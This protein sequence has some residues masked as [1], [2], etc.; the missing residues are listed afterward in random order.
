[1]IFELHFYSDTYTGTIKMK[2]DSEQD[3]RLKLKAIIPSA[4]G[5]NFVKEVKDGKH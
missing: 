3:A 5:I 1:M 2:A 4:T